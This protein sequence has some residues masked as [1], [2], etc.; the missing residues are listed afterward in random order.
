MLR[1]IF[2]LLLLMSV[3]HTAAQST[4]AWQGYASTDAVDEP[5]TAPLDSQAHV[6]PYENEPFQASYSQNGDPNIRLAEAP[7]L[8]ATAPFGPSSSDG[9]SPP[10]TKSLLPPG[11]R[12]GMFQKLLFTNAYAPAFDDSSAGFNQIEIAVLLGLPFP[13]RET[14]LLITPSYG[15]R[16]LDGPTTLDVPSRLHDA[17]VDFHH[18]RRIHERWIFDTAVTVGTYGDDAELGTSDSIRVSGRALGI[19]ELSPEWKG[20]VGVV[21]LNRAGASIIPAAGLQYDTPDV[22]YDLVFPRPRAAYRIW[23]DG[24]TPGMNERWVYVMAEF[25]GGIWAVERA[26]GASDT[27]SYSDYR[28]LIGTER[29]IVGGLSRK[30]E[31]GY[32]FGREFEYDSGPAVDLDDTLLVRMLWT[33]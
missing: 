10:G 26:S 18:F 31:F 32:V 2:T 20:I 23:Y 12:P 11:T 28:L 16:F 13:E 27:L 15:V 24:G 8:P 5:W 19:Y 25:G 7:G 3:Q 14:P 4:Q 21:Y 29:K 1:L 22:K 6:T 30:F 17:E 9:T 33:Y